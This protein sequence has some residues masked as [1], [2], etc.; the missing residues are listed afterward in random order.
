MKKTYTIFGMTC[1]SCKSTIH[2]NLNE[3]PEVESVEVNLEKAEAIIFMKSNI[4]I[5]KLQNAL[6]SKFHIEEKIVDDF[7]ALINEREGWVWIN[8]ASAARAE[9]FLSLLRE[10]LGNLPVVLVDTQKSPVMSMTQWVLHGPSSDPVSY[11]HLTMPTI[12]SV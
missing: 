9:D 2:Q 7:D 1:N 11:T 5:S 6:P 12:Y 8:T 10:A 3:I 4:E